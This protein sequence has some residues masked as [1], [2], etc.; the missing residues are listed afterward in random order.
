MVRLGQWLITSSGVDAGRIKSIRTGEDVLKEAS[1]GDEI[2]LAI[3][4]VTAGRQINEGETLYV[5]LLESSIKELP[6]MNL[7]SDETVAMEELLVIKRK[8]DPFWG[9]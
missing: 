3:D 9:M 6:K 4:G 7:N 8:E 1:Q 2:A 5:D